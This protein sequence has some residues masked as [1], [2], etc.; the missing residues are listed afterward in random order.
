MKFLAVEQLSDHKYK[1]PE[2]Y[3]ICVDSVLARTGKQSY[4]R[5]EVFSDSDDETEIEID[6]SPEEVFSEKT[7]ASFENKPICIQHPD[8]DVTTNNYKDLAVGFVRDIKRGES[9]GQDVML[10]TLV[11]TDSE[12]IRMVEEGELTDLSC[13]YDCDIA[14]EPNPQ[15]RNIRGNHV[16]LC[17]QGRAGIARIVDSV[18][19]VKLPTSWRKDIAR[20]L[21]ARSTYTKRD[22]D[23]SDLVSEIERYMKVDGH[24]ITL[25]RKSIKGWFKTGDGMM[26]KDYQFGIEGYSDNIQIS[27][28]ADPD[29]YRVTEINAAFNDSVKDDWNYKGYTIF[30]TPYGYTVKKDGKVIGQF[31]NDK[32]AEEAID[33]MTNDVEDSIKDADLTE[34]SN[35]LRDALDDEAATIDLYD[36]ILS[37]PDTPEDVKS[38]I[39]E[40]EDD[41]KD[42]YKILAELVDEDAKKELKGFGDEM[43]DESTEEINKVISGEVDD[44]LVQSS[45]KEA[46]KKNVATE[47]KSGKDPK[48][49]AA[50]AYSVKRKNDSVNDRVDKELS[51]EAKKL[52][53]D[54]NLYKRSGGSHKGTG[55]GSKKNI[56]PWNSNITEAMN[57]ALQLISEGVHPKDAIGR[58][59]AYI[60]MYEDMFR[61]MD[62]TDSNYNKLRDVIS[63]AKRI[64]EKLLKSRDS[65][66]DKLV[67]P[68]EATIRM[69]ESELNKMGVRIVATGKTW[70]GRKHYQVEFDGEPHAL[71]NRLNRVEA[72]MK[73]ENIPMTYAVGSDGNGVS[74]A[75]ID[76]DKQYVKDHAKMI[77]A[78]NIIKK[79]R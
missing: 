67:D 45:S 21:H 57:D 54:L 44:D 46:F 50:I 38:K 75:G 79:L 32:E 25:Y 76:L 13:G 78:I 5:N 49:A 15:Q 72:I 42:H 69:F 24:P 22:I 33:N 39:K 77:K 17:E 10:G 34:Y 36:E 53:A 11:I 6:R 47:I 48:Q 58:L 35:L 16:A 37:H 14:D 41:E 61:D 3:L 2:G 9:D 56:N 23:V 1:T 26:R 4:R 74:S 65:M 19:D 73:K 63:R 30:K 52:K 12:A 20:I 29:T 62:K 43:R 59:N 60:G 28:Y 66:K 70:T 51:E 68:S 7:L 71:A 31:A 18:K 27:L 55:T 40:I 8:E 64:K